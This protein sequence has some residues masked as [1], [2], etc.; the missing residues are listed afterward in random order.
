[1]AA[2]PP[3]RVG[4]GSQREGRV[5]REGPPEQGGGELGQGWCRERGS[6]PT[7]LQWAAVT[8]QDWPVTDPPQK[9]KPL[10]SWGQ[11]LAVGVGPG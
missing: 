8:A 1:M 9:Q 2:R 5:T 7:T 10:L 11:G 3:V 6:N 4:L